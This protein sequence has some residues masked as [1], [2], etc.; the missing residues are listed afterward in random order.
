MAD[1]LF[2]FMGLAVASVSG[3]FFILC[4]LTVGKHF[5]KTLRAPGTGEFP[6]YFLTKRIQKVIIVEIG[7]RT[8]SEG[9]LSSLL[10]NGAGQSYRKDKIQ[11][12]VFCNGDG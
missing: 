11:E 6:K 12:I 7:V 4:L 1:I 10:F 3:S 8:A 5:R 9:G 2:E